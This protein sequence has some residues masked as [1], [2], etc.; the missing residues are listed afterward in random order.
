MKKN[1]KK[2]K[3]KNNSFRKNYKKKIKKNSSRKNYKKKSKKYRKKRKTYHKISHKN[4]RKFYKNNLM[5]TQIGGMEAA[6]APSQVEF[7][8]PHRIGFELE[9]CFDSEVDPNYTTRVC[10]GLREDRRELFNKIF[11]KDLNYFDVE[12]DNSI[13]CP[14]PNSSFNVPK[15][16]SL[17]S[18]ELILKN[19]NIF[20]Y[21][22]KEIYMDDMPISL[23]LMDE[24]FLISSKAHACENSSCG[25]HVHISETDTPENMS[26][27][28]LN[29]KEGKL[30]LL[31]A[32]ALWC[33]VGDDSQSKQYEFIKKG[34]CRQECEATDSKKCYAKLLPPLNIEEFRSVYDL[35]MIDKLTNEKL[36]DY[37]KQVYKLPYGMSMDAKYH[38]FNIYDLERLIGFDH[39]VVKKG[40][41]QYIADYCQFDSV[42]EMNKHIGYYEMFLS[43][44][45]QLNS[46]PPR[47]T[48]LLKIL[49]DA[50]ISETEK[51][52]EF[53]ERSETRSRNHLLPDRRGTYDKVWGRKLRIE[54]RGHKDLIETIN[55]KTDLYH[56]AEGYDISSDEAMATMI[57][58]QWNREHTRNLAKASR[59]YDHLMEYLEDINLFFTEARTYEPFSTG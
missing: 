33:G 30:F 14:G 42:D 37:L 34:Y 6:A 7:S 23:N 18:M 46:P 12:F 24:I 55:G 54:F 29:Q 38:A 19:D 22:D 36:L 27:N 44:N 17:C 4:L 1:S 8:K 3:I 16:P 52:S 41:R 53:L 32:L 58:P 9:A 49:K 10:Q 48:A 5:R 43:K 11:G 47:L 50:G 39:H 2:K 21:N 31:R 35:A 26:I 25:F 20:T 13:Q 51:P 56:Q 28:N 59:F 40:F 57:G 15:T 45:P